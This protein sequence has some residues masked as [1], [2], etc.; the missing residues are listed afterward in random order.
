MRHNIQSNPGKYTSPVKPVT[1][2]T[3]FRQ[4]IDTGLE[5]G[6][7]LVA[8]VF[9]IFSV[10]P[11]AFSNPQDGQV[12]GGSA[13]IQQSGPG[14]VDVIQ[15]SQ[16]AIID[17]RS[18]SIS[19]GEHAHFQQPSVSALALNRV[20]G[21]ESSVI[22]GAL[23]ANGKV[24]L[25]NSNGVLFGQG[26]RVNVGSLIATTTDIDNTNFMAGRYEFDQPSSN[27]GAAVVNLGSIEVADGGA[28]ALVA[29]KVE[30]HGLIR[31]RLG[32]VALASGETF[33]VDFDGDG[34]L[35]F[36]LGGQSRQ[37]DSGSTG[38][39]SNAGI[40]NS[41]TILA[42]GGVVEMTAQ[43]KNALIDR[44]INMDGVIQARAV[45]V[46][47]GRI[48]LSGG[49]H[50]QVEVTG[51]LDA[52]GKDAGQHGGQVKVLGEQVALLDG[53]SVDVSGAAGG[54][55]AL[56]G[57]NYKGQGPEP[58]A[59]A[60]TV[61]G[62][63]NI[64]ADALDSGDG[65]KIIVWSDERAEIHGRLSARGGTAS[66]D[67]GLIETSAK[68]D[69]RLT[70]VGDASAPNGKGGAWLIDPTDIL[71]TA[72]TEGAIGTN[73]VG[74]DLINTALNTGTSVFLATS[75]ATGGSGA[76]LGDITQQNGAPIVKSAG[77][78][79]SLFLNAENNITLFDTITSTTGGLAV[80]LF[81]DDDFNGTGD[82]FIGAP[83][84]TGGGSIFIDGQNINIANADI[85]TAGGLLFLRAADSFSSNALL[86]SSLA[87]GTAGDID[88]FAGNM[89]SANRIDSSGLVPGVITLAGN[90][91]NLTGGI[92]SVRGG[93]PLHLGSIDATTVPVN[94]GGA[95]DTGPAVLDI[96][97]S[98]LAAVADG[99]TTI[100]IETMGAISVDASGMGVFDNLDLLGNS[101]TVN[102]PVATN[103]NSVVLNAVTNVGVNSAISTTGGHLTINGVT[104]IQGEGMETP[105]NP[106][107][108][109][110][111][112]MKGGD[113]PIDWVRLIHEGMGIILNPN[114]NFDLNGDITT[115]GGRFTVNAITRVGSGA[116]VVTTGGGDILFNG[117]IDA[118]SAPANTA[119]TLDSTGTGGSDQVTVGAI[120]QMAPLDTLTIGGSILNLS[121][122]ATSGNLSLRGNEIDL[123][124]GVAS[125]KGP[126][127]LELRAAG[128]TVPVMM[129]G[130][131][132][133]GASVLDLTNTDLAA[134][135]DGFSSIR[136]EGFDTITIDPTG[137][138]LFD[139]LDLFGSSIL[140]NGPIGINGNDLSFNAT[141]V[142]EA[143][144]D[145]MTGGGNFTVNGST[146]LPAGTRTV[147]TSGGNIVFNGTIE[148]ASA[149]EFVGLALDSGGS[150]VAGDV[151]AGDIG[152]TASLDG[153][154]IL[155]ST[156]NLASVTTTGAQDYT[157]IQVNV[158]SRFQTTGGDFKVNGDTVLAPGAHTVDTLGG[159]I[160]FNGTIDA[161]A[162][163]D[164]VTLAL[165]SSSGGAAGEVTAG[166][167]GQTDSLDGLTILGSTL[168]LAD[169]TTTGTQDYTGSQVNF[170]S[171]YQTTGGDFTVNGNTLLA[172]G[173][174]TVD[175]L[176][177]NI[178][179]NGTVNALS[180]S[181]LTL[182]AGVG[183]I[184]FSNDVGT[185]IKLGNVDIGS[186]RD[187]RVNGQFV[188]A[189]TQVFHSGSFDTGPAGF[190]IV[191]GLFVNPNA[192]SATLAGTVA[193]RSDTATAEVVGGPVDDPN[194]T[195]NGC[196]IGVSCITAPGLPELPIEAQPQRS[197]GTLVESAQGTTETTLFALPPVFSE[198]P[199]RSPSDDPT[200]YQYSNMGNEE[201]WDVK[202]GAAPDSPPTPAS[203]RRGMDQDA[204]QPKQNQAAPRE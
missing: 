177:G 138:N 109:F 90:E 58:N 122:I 52:S 172:S 11:I 173:G 111:L 44:V 180:N 17:W 50:G 150:G 67:G 131:A 204:D 9:W 60:T 128:S 15:G 201:F 170:G 76:D 54:G 99:F 182:S 157:G 46:M 55:E 174:Q 179:F 146:R 148:A 178:L 92:A 47:G 14:R 116:H 25:V 133:S 7:A 101:I 68:K 110:D 64:Q 61:A 93:G 53:A 43:T 135:A 41:G 57:G 185:E 163:S 45:D 193:G 13:S 192:R 39:S 168:N 197:T 65:G 199:Q 202:S 86:D 29:P 40:S 36:D 181:D 70:S 107:E 119:L 134:L 147:A 105:S 132:D 106:S 169:V 198:L 3:R 78:D 34:L 8:I 24:I 137:I 140:V 4:R 189:D 30:N 48:V 88:I 98:D 87:D 130:V 194:F 151:S 62:K 190:L 97:D 20:R 32:K 114:V 28:V 127:L 1:R 156:L 161:R 69:L 115:A 164:L 112:S 91:I 155:G 66:G 16:N 84:S 160:V 144:A 5:V 159:D 102:G 117:T 165:D 23:T 166:A 191:D 142:V 85:T 162:S 141:V 186:A 125:V 72:G 89:L 183:D 154:T 77:G 75:T 113:T 19:S 2:G 63:A 80:F 108:N 71:I 6:L 136:I 38:H 176:G 118:A 175:T 37:T 153:L 73:Q 124:G 143:N 100:S 94:L 129:G 171:R 126:G 121:S 56:I 31:A 26:S 145:I 95:A 167:I 51:K 22:D 12:V 104:L 10:A 35:Q 195:I 59:A 79:A 188:A 49:E 81:A 187:V 33:S 203:D 200:Q 18:F 103:G 152:Q 139:P 184:Y 21:P 82:V 42:D 120:G 27:A 149:A 123:T 83:I 96:T 158:S 74:V 196:V